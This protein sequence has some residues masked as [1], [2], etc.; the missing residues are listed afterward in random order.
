MNPDKHV[1]NAQMIQSYPELNIDMDMVLRGMGTDP[2]IIRQRKP[3]LV[4][5]AEQALK[6]G[7]TLIEPV[8]AYRILAVEEMRHDGFKLADNVRLK[9]ALLVQQLACAEKIAVLVCTLGSALEKRVA[10]LMHE[11]P[12][13]AFA[14]DGFGSMAA[15]ALGVTVCAELEDEARSAGLYT[16]IPLNPGMIGWTVDVGQPQIFTALNADKI[17]VTLN[18]SAQMIPYKSV[19]MVLGI[20]QYPFNAGRPCDFCS[21]NTTCRYQNHTA[22]LDG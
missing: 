16:S 19:S 4:V 5:L 21:M 6:E 17:G 14:L 15:E 12:A 7:L 10:A 13:F 22:R 9:G 1:L 3:R 2:L 20:S 18:T 11:D 8:A